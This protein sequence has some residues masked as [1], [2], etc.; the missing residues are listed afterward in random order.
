MGIKEG[1][2]VTFQEQKTNKEKPF[3]DKRNKDSCWVPTYG[4]SDTRSVWICHS[5]EFK[6]E[7][8]SL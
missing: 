6:T 3:A 5:L 8:H 2:K 1:E 7:R 4:S